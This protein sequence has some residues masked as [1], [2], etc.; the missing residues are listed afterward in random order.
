[1]SPTT[2]TTDHREA[3]VVCPETAARCNWS[4]DDE[5]DQWTAA[6]VHSGTAHERVRFFRAVC[7]G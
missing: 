5:F 7:E 4:T 3:D 1:M 6:A 2:A